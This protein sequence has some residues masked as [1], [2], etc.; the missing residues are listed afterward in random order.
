MLHLLGHIGDYGFGA[1]LKD[2]LPF[3]E[4]SN[5]V[6][7]GT[8]AL[9]IRFHGYLCDISAAAVVVMATEGIM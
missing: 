5:R 8:G 7:G 1:S 6:R 9:L 3:D 2:Q 4:G